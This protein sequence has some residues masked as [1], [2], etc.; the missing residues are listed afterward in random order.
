MR[1]SLLSRPAYT[2]ATRVNCSGTFATAV[3]EVT[4]L[5]IIGPGLV[6]GDD[7]ASPLL[8]SQQ[9]GSNVDIRVKG[10]R[11]GSPPPFPL[12]MIRPA[13]QTSEKCLNPLVVLILFPR[14][15]LSP[16]NLTRS[17]PVLHRTTTCQPIDLGG[18]ILLTNF[19]K[20]VTKYMPGCAR[21]A[22]G[23]AGVVLWKKL[24]AP[25]HCTAF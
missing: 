10:L 5:E 12:C 18:P 24:R 15:I 11:H 9:Q 19:V 23:N 8:H 17:L 7:Q 13:K 4:S 20:S 3:A 14:L 2:Q 16:C 6:T 25:L 22:L 21:R 1:I